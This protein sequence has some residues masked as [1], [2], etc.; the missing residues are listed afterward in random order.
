MK[1]LDAFSTTIKLFFHDSF[2]FEIFHG[3]NILQC[4]NFFILALYFAV[5][6]QYIV[7]IYECL[8][9][10]VCPCNYGAGLR[11]RIQSAKKAVFFLSIFT[12]GP[13]ECKYNTFTLS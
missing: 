9:W 8:R 11:I 13:K 2:C 6:F 5:P 4:E 10:I 3:T 1:P 7:F 12:D